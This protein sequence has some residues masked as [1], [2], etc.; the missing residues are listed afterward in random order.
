M[1]EFQALRT[2]TQN[3]AKKRNFTQSFISGI[4]IAHVVVVVM[5]FD[6]FHLVPSTHVKVILN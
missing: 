4:K 5:L 3:K 2:E 1:R 6:Q